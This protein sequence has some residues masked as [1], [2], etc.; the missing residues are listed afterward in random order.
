MPQFASGLDEVYVGR[1]RKDPTV[2]M[3]LIFGL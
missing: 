1:I 2:P 3:G